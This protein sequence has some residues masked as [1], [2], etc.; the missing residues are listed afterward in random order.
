MPA[1]RIHAA[2]RSTAARQPVLAGRPRRPDGRRGSRRRRRE[3]PRTRR[4][5]RAAR[6]PRRGR[7]RSTRACGSR[8]G[9]D[10]AEP[11]PVELLDVAVERTEVGHPADRSDP[12]VLAEDVGVLDD[13]DLAERRAAK[14]RFRPRRGGELR[15]VA[16][17]KPAQTGF[18]SWNAQPGSFTSREADEQLVEELALLGV[19]RCEDTRPRAP[20]SARGAARS[21]R[22]PAGVML[23]TWR[24]R[25]SGSRCRTINSRSS[26]PSRSATR[27][28]GSR[29]SAPGDRPLSLARA[30][31][32]DREQAVVVELAAGL[33]DAAGSP[34]P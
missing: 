32:E 24:R 1:A 4:P 13:V 30:F 8:R 3:A 25:S 10:R 26:S 21:S 17:E 9:R 33:L 14:G 22:L 34:C 15:E 16:D 27:R 11:A 5:R 28:L 12:P 29:A 7:P 18:V 6:T 31:G 23:T 19:E 2:C 20:G